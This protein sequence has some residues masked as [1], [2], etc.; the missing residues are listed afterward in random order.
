MKGDQSL[1]YGDWEGALNA[2]EEAYRFSSEAETLTAA[3]LGIGRAYYHSGDYSTALNT[4]RD[5]V[6]NYPD[7]PRVAEAYF[8]LGQIYM[9]LD[10]YSEAADAYLNYLARRHGIIDAYVYELRGD[11][12]FTSGD[13][14]SALIDYQAAYQSP[15]LGNT[16]TLEIKMA[17]AYAITGDTTTAVIMYQDIYNRTNPMRLTRLTWM[18]SRIFLKLMTPIPGWWSW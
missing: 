3:Q 11:A 13:Y 14:P 16:F 18:Q 17:R 5:L 7:A 6:E 12:L 15:R 10:R 2:Y 8:F 1:F 4:L 9:A